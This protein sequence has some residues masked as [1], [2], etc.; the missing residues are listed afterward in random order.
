M[1]PASD[2]TR[3]R[4]IV[5]CGGTGGHVFPGVAMACELQQRGHAVELW[6][7]GRDVEQSASFGWEGPTECIPARG[8]PSG[9]SWRTVWRGAR[10]LASTGRCIRRLRRGRRPAAVLAMGGYASVGPGL[11]AAALGIPLILHESNAI[12]GRAIVFLSRWATRIALTFPEATETLTGTNTTVTGF[13]LRAGGRTG[14]DDFAG[15][16]PHSTGECFTILVTGGSQGAQRLNEI[17]TE[18]LCLLASRGI[19]FQVIHLTGPRDESA[20]RVRYRQAGVSAAV[21]GFLQRMDK[22]YEAAHFAICRAGAATCAELSAAGV[23]A[24]LIPLPSAA[25]DHQTANAMAVAHDGAADLIAQ[26]TLQPEWLADYLADHVTMP[27]T[28]DAMREAALKRAIPDGAAR[29]ADV[30]EAALPSLRCGG[31]R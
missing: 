24:L 31:D 6:L 20:V 29:T 23:P 3:Q 21:F 1:T 5:A 10:L 25:R 8:L 15:S 11:A 19:R 12:P 2:E 16:L 13:P 14:A 22:A 17:V 18:G 26:E 27:D 30:V 7:A 4:L 9:I 28:L